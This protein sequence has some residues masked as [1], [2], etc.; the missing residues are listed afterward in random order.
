MSFSFLGQCR[1]LSF[2]SLF[3]CLLSPFSFCP[4]YSPRG[5]WAEG[6]VQLAENL[7]SLITSLWITS[8]PQEIWAL[9]SQRTKCQF[10][11]PLSASS[12]Q[13]ARMSCRG[14]RPDRLTRSTLES[15]CSHPPYILEAPAGMWSEF[16]HS[17]PWPLTVSTFVDSCSLSSPMALNDLLF[18]DNSLVVLQRAGWSWLSHCLLYGQTKAV[19]LGQNTKLIKDWL[20]PLF[21]IK[22]NRS[23]L[24]IIFD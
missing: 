2:I 12:K 11:F 19:F 23:R 15:F 10:S 21:V 9:L 18:V 3:Y 5:A 13:Q 17:R 4:F 1:V 8:N 6:H 7:H 24:G 16:K 22:F 20:K 14:P